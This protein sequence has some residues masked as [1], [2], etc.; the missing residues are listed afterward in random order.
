MYTSLGLRARGLGRTGV[1]V[2]GGTTYSG[3]VHV[4]S[5]PLKVGTV[6]VEWPVSGQSMGA[7]A[8]GL[9]HRE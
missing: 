3:V 6:I 9:W 7:M 5:K 2:V 1:S 8:S 4:A